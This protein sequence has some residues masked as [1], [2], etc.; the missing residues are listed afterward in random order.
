M[1]VPTLSI[2]FMAISMLFCLGFPFIL[3]AIISKKFNARYA[4]FFIGWA[5][6]LLFAI[7]LEPI[8]HRHVLL[9]ASGE[10][11]QNNIWLYA[12]YSGLAAG[13][14]EET[15]RF[16][17]FKTV[18]RKSKDKSDSIMY[19]AGHGGFEAIVVAGMSMLSNLIISAMINL[20]ITDIFTAS[21]PDEATLEAMNAQFTALVTTPSSS[22]LLSSLERLIAVAL[23]IALS[24]LVYA[25]AKKAK[26]FWL[27]PAAI[28]LHAFVD[29][30][31]V[32]LA[33]GFGLNLFLAEGILAVMTAAIALFAVKV[34][35]SM[36]NP[37]EE[38]AVVPASEQ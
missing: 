38:N 12:L 4:P 9:G 8:L 10:A 18:L 31:L 15:G 35:R 28:L 23:H 3:M 32:I 7:I 37:E 27:F 26:R 16:V 24:V 6:F 2:L 34:Y 17:A 19:G 25:A 29:A 20:G 30:V 11:I 21:A 1:T 5:V 36:D 33:N 22:F 14:F 13:I